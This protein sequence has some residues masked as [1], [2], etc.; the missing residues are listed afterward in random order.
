MTK[1]EKNEDGDG[2]KEKEIGSPFWRKGQK[3]IIE[4]TESLLGWVSD[5]T[6]VKIYV[7][8]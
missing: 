2:R 6:D 3:S 7:E 4:V 8:W 5:G 1:E